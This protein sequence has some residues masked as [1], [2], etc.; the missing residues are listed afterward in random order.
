[1]G[2][3]AVVTDSDMRDDQMES[4]RGASSSCRMRGPEVVSGPGNSRSDTNPHRQ[5]IQ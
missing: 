3:S 2:D 4:N 1:M 5:R